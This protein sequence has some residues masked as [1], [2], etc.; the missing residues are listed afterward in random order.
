MGTFALGGFVLWLVS[1]PMAGFLLDRVQLMPYFLLAHIVGLLTCFLLDRKI[2]LFAIP[3]TAVVALFTAVYPYVGSKEYLLILIGFMSAFTATYTGFLISSQ[4]SINSFFGLALGN[5]GSLFIS[6]FPVEKTFKYLLSAVS[7]VAVMYSPKQ[8]PQADKSL[9]SLYRMLPYF[10]VFYATGGLMYKG[11]LEF[12]AQV[13]YL[14]GLEVIFYAMGV[15]VSY[16]LLS[17]LGE[18]A[19]VAVSAFLNA[20]AY[21]LLQMGGVHLLNLSMFLL[22][23]GFG[24]ADFLLLF[25][26]YNIKDTIRAFSLGFATVCV[27]IVLGYY[28]GMLKD[29]AEFFT[30]LGS[31]MLVASLVYYFSTEKVP[32]EVSE[33]LPQEPSDQEEVS[34]EKFLNHLQNS[35]HKKL[36]PREFEVL[37]HLLEGCDYENISQKMGLST[38]SVREYTRRALLK[39]EMDRESLISM[40]KDWM[41][42]YA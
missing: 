34:A 42:Q 18:K 14:H 41:H 17:L 31:L 28:A 24:F 33:R 19:L 4:G 21:A 13:S 39:L 22:Q 35:L 29:Y 30:G 15:L 37:L 40:Y 6:F 11:V 2:L 5:V 36:S 26:L 1:F 16:K 10:L 25:T 12:Y 32:K 9:H 27:G 8:V 7:L 23:A 20:T 38:S 3:L